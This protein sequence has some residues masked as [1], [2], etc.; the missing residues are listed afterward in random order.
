[1]NLPVPSSQHI[2]VV[3]LTLNRESPSLPSPI[4]LDL[5][6]SPAELAR[7]KKEPLSIKEGVDYQ[8]GISFRVENQIVSGLRYLQVVKRSGIKGKLHS[9]SPVLVELG[10]AR[11]GLWVLLETRD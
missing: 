1:L 5:T 7:Y 3:P 9:F 10:G 4:V 6:Q 2:Q 11:K 8:V